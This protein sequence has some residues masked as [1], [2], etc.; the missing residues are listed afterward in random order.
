MESAYF[1]MYSPSAGP[2]FDAIAVFRHQHPVLF[3]ALASIYFIP[4]L[5]GLLA[6]SC[7]IRPRDTPWLHPIFLTDGF[8]VCCCPLASVLPVVLWPAWLLGVLLAKALQWFSNAPTY[9]GVERVT[10]RRWGRM[11]RSRL[12]WRGRKKQTGAL[13]PTDGGVS[14][15]GPGYGS[16]GHARGPRPEP[17][18]SPGTRHMRYARPPT[19]DTDAASVRS[20]PPPYHE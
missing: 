8:L 13:L 18:R 6:L 17:Y 3:Y 15:A 14:S 4:A 20:V 1:P 12:T 5:A 9:C 2:I 11:W 10:V 19:T 16:L 7:C